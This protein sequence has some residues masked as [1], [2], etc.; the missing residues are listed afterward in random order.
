MKKT[1]L[2]LLFLLNHFCFANDSINQQNE[3]IEKS[4]KIAQKYFELPENSLIFHSNYVIKHAKKKSDVGLAY[5]YL[6]NTY[7]INGNLDKALICYRKENEIFKNLLNSDNSIENN[8]NYAISMA[9]IAIVYSQQS[10]YT[11][12]LEYHFMAKDIFL[13]TNNIEK[14]AA[15]SNNIGIEYQSLNKLELANKY[16]IDATKYNT[17]VKVSNL[18]LFTNIAKNYLK[19]NDLRL[20]NT[21]FNKA[22]ASIQKNDENYLIGE[23]HNNLA[24]FYYVKKEY[25][26]MKSYLDLAFVELNGFDFGLSDSYYYLGLYE[27]TQK[28]ENNAFAAFDKALKICYQLNLNELNLEIEKQLVLMYE[29]KGDYK[30]AF[31]HQQKL[32]ALQETYWK[33]NSNKALAYTEMISNFEKNKLKLHTL[34]ETQRHNL[35]IYIAVSLLLFGIIVFLFYVNR[36]KLINKNLILEKDK[37]ELHHKALHL[38]MNP[39]FIFNCLGSISSFI[40]QNENETAITY[41]NHFARLMRLTLENS[42]DKEISIEKEI[43]SLKQYFELEKLR[44]ESIFDY[45]IT[46]NIHAENDIMIPPM[47]LQPIIEN[48]IIHGIM[49]KKTN[50]KIDV[51]FDIHLDKLVCTIKDNGVGYFKSL[52]LKDGSVL[53]HKSIALEVL[54]ERIKTLGGTFEI[55]ENNGTKVIITLVT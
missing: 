39:H 20:A 21:Y 23:L 19:K 34:E 8:T 25:S 15:I 6:G 35:Y 41:L 3:K 13:R 44:Y 48:A 28:K 52:K 9:S 55:K 7:K 38:Q 42:K 2:I 30:L 10:N 43:E 17:K 51:V 27:L 50:G 54:K 45:T 5:H 37:A 36:Q 53:A 22:I 31:S 49:P 16:F 32:S 47:L 4:L 33:N 11:K 24:Y 40:L 26:T 14:L 29:I 1:Y 46:N 18:L 12:A